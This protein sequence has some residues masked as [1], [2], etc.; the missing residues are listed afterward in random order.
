MALILC[1]MHFHHSHN[2]ATDHL[3]CM[4]VAVIWHVIYHAFFAMTVAIEIAESK[5]KT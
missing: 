5:I 4:F 1:Q 3:S 2:T